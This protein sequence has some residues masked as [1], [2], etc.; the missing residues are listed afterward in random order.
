MRVR[1]TTIY[2]SAATDGK[3]SGGI[4]GRLLGS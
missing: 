4:L 1:I 2:S 3:K